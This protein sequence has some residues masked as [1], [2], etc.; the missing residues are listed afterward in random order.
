MK[1][2]ENR[3][4]LQPIIES[5]IFLGRQNIPLR[6]HRDDGELKLANSVGSNPVNEGNFR[7]LL[8]FRVQSGDENLKEHLQTA[9]SRATYVSKRTQNEIIF[10]CG[11][12]ILEIIK[13]RIVEAN[14]YS[15]IFDETTDL[16]HTS[17]MTLAIRYIHDGKVREDF[18]KFIDVRACATEECD[19]PTGIETDED[20]LNEELNKN[21]DPMLEEVVLSGKTLGK[22]VVKILNELSLN[23]EKCV[24]I[25]TDGCSVMTSES[26]GA[27]QEIQ[28]QARHAVRS[29]CFN[30]NLNLSLSKSSR[31]QAVR[32]ATGTIQ[33]TVSFFTSS[34]KQNHVLK[35]FVD[36]QLPAL[37]ETR[38]VERQTSFLQFRAKFPEIIQALESVA[39][40]Q[41][42]DAASKARTLISALLNSTFI[43]TVVCMCHVFSLTLPFSKIL[44]KTEIDL[45]YALKHFMDVATALTNQRCT[46]DVC[47]KDVFQEAK[48]I[49]E[50]TNFEMNIPRTSKFQKNRANYPTND[51]ETYFRLSVFIP[52]L[53]SILEDFKSRFPKE[54]LE[55]YNLH[56]CMPEYLIAN[57]TQDISN[58]L[59]CLVKRYSG[60]FVV[61]SSEMKCLLKGELQ[62]WRMQWKHK[63][64]LPK[65][66]MDALDTCDIDLFPI[67]HKLLHILATLPIS[68]ASAERSFQSLKR[69]KS[70]LRTRMRQDRLTGLALLNAHRDIHVDPM[71]VLERFSKSGNRR[72]DFDV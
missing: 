70:W 41:D 28:K 17:Q 38:W 49:A 9:S 50:K 71:Q 35:H 6:G 54:T 7:E 27:V 53:D 3:K 29:P 55:L 36:G 51:P 25:G 14:Y 13:Q 64:T 30:H 42:L 1:I 8:K 59:E 52:I 67:V 16:S 48:E 21:I 46:A 19:L 20:I 47:F 15:I 63:D 5:I 56:V 61:T 69:I 23:I 10:C 40:W 39:S 22:I 18:I 24:G 37:C 12:E 34:S 43:I 2:Q 4:R 62:L 45:K 33:E 68:N 72:L 32:N 57:S 31:I 58:E 66:V 60:L 65:T 44:Q 26:K 11:Q